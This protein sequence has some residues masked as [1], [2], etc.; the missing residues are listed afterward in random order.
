M[1]PE[2]DRKRYEQLR[3]Q[4][5]AGQDSLEKW[6]LNL[7]QTRGMAAWLNA[8]CEEQSPRPPAE[9]L[10]PLVPDDARLPEGIQREVATVLAEMILDRS[11]EFAGSFH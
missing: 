5:L 11:S 6:G 4:V 7:L 1:S 2:D 3:E 8:A 9:S 10:R